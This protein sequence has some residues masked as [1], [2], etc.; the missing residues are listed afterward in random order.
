MGSLNRR[1]KFCPMH[2][3]RAAAGG[4]VKSDLNRR[5]AAAY[6]ACLADGGHKPSGQTVRRWPSGNSTTALGVE[7]VM[8]VCAR[9]AVP[10]V[11]PSR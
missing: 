4:W 2:G 8:D 10:F 11:A 5:V 6:R 9:C 7:V 3:Y 1:R